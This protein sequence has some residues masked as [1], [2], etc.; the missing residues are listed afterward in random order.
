MVEIHVVGAWIFLNRYAGS[1]STVSDGSKT[2]HQV[3]RPAER[4]GKICRASTRYAQ[5]IPVLN[6]R[7]EGFTYTERDLRGRY[8]PRLVMRFE[9][10][11]NG[12]GAVQRY[13]TAG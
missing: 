7:F 5:K 8:S 4:C 9:P 2:H 6:H 3:I 13:S 12:F 10:I 11:K 1:E